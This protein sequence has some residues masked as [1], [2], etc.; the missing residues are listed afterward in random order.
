ML[1]DVVRGCPALEIPGASYELIRLW[2]MLWHGATSSYQD[3][4]TMPAQW[5]EAFRFLDGELIAL[6]QEVKEAR[7]N[8]NSK[9]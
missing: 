3:R 7:G 9:S 2:E 8:T 6:Q 1:G 4:L 5:L